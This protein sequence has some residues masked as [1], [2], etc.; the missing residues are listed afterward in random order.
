M[1]SGKVKTM[2]TKKKVNGCQGFEGGKINT[3]QRIFRAVK[4][5]SV[6]YHNDGSVSLY[7]CP[8]PQNVHPVSP[9]VNYGLWVLMMCL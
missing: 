1:T 7:T 8:N 4:L 2:E 3:E 5:Y 9:E 6:W